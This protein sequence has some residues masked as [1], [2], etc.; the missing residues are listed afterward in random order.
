MLPATQHYDYLT[1]TAYVNK[2]ISEITTLKCLLY[3]RAAPS[4]LIR[5]DL[6]VCKIKTLSSQIF[7]D[8]HMSGGFSLFPPPEHFFFHQNIIA[9]WML[10]IINPP[11]F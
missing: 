3:S 1:K 5:T 10:N 4:K 11:E 9:S 6:A 2:R 8:E 7:K